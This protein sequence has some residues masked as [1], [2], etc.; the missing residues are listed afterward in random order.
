MNVAVIVAIIFAVLVVALLAAAYY[1]LEYRP[2]KEL[3]EY[4][5]KL[6]LQKDTKLPAFVLPAL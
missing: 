4:G 1:F 3:K 5:K 6:K 2:N